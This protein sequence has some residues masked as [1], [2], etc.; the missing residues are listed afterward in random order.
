M[1]AFIGD[2]RDA[3]GVEAICR[4]WDREQTV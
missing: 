3:Y 2:D 1:I 4:H